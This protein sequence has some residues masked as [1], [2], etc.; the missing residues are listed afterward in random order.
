MNLP[1]LLLG[2]AT[3]MAAV[4][5]G[6]A[7]R[8]AWWWA[9]L[10]ACAALAWL[11]GPRLPLLGVALGA[12]TVALM[13][14]WRLLDAD[15]LVEPGVLRTAAVLALGAGQLAAAT[16][17]VNGPGI[18]WWPVLALTGG[19]LSRLVLPGRPG[20]ILAVSA[21]TGDTA[22]ALARGPD[23]PSALTLLA[24]P[25]AV[26]LLWARCSSRPPPSR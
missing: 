1:P 24:C 22:I 11:S 25:L 6:L 12:Q 21:L 23:L 3:A 4:L 14:A 2:A 15:W 16:L 8:P 18:N 9:G 13:V 26:L 10:V 5:W 17:A 7:V 19:G 20:H